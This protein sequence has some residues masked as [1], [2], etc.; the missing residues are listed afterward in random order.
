MSEIDMAAIR[1]Q[2][3]GGQ[4][5][6]KLA[7]A[8]HLR[9]DIANSPSLPEQVRKRLLASGDQR[10]TSAGVVVIKS[11]ESRSQERNRQVALERLGEMLRNATRTRKP[12]V[13]TRPGKAAK[14]KRL[15]DKSRRGQVKR[16][17]GRPDDG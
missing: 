5:V 4:N 16:L 1:S 7:T 9:F 13:P 6:N 14:R 8:I 12:R 17:R 2:G 15:D 3:A 10:I 11:Q